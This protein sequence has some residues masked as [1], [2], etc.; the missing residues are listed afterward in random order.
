[1]M[2]YLNQGSNGG[3][4]TATNKA[5]KAFTFE[6]DQKGKPRQTKGTSQI[7]TSKQK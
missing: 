5:K 2:K 4:S 6:V 3:A 7:A 1:M